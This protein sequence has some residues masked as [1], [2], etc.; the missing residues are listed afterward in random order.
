MADA[1]F[2]LAMSTQY[3]HGHGQSNRRELPFFPAPGSST[4]QP[5]SLVFPIS[6]RWLCASAAHVT[7]IRIEA[8]AVLRDDI[9]VC[10]DH[11][12]VTSTV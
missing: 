12:D 4:V 1:T 8:L 7:E 9:Q 3:L 11:H 10:K 5:P 6:S 2:C